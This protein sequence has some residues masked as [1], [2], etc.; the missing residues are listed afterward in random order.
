MR[1]KYTEGDIQ[2]CAYIY[3]LNVDKESVRTQNVLNN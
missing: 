2:G 1:R 3:R